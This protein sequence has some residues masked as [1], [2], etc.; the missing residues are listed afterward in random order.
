MKKR[1]LFL[2]SVLLLICIAVSFTACSDNPAACL[3]CID[4]DLDGKCDECGKAVE[5]QHTECIDTNADNKCDECG[6]ELPVV[7]KKCVDKNYDG[8]CDV[9]ESAVS[10][11][12]LVLLRNGE[13][14]FAF[15]VS[16]ALPEADRAIVAETI[17][18]LKDLGLNVSAYT[19]DEDHGKA[20]EILVG[21]VSSRG[22]KFLTEERS[23]GYEGYS[24]R[25]IDGKG[26]IYAGSDIA[27]SNAFTYFK[28]NVLKISVL[29][30]VIASADISVNSYSVCSTVSL[31]KL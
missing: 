9:C 13:V 8:K 7:C 20:V 19:E 27:L 6:K 31:D 23:L 11:D 17:L 15:V 26:V 29:S 12:G 14:N 18:S 5:K 4:S 24:L 10:V 28:E 1:I 2:A 30:R 22:D 21:N 25:I 16:D 3:E